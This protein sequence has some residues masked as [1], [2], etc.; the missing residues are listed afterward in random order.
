MTDILWSGGRGACTE[1][2][3]SGRRLLAR[4]GGR[5]RPPLHRSVVEAR[6]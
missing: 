6:L 3:R 4:F 2:S 5:G 1:R